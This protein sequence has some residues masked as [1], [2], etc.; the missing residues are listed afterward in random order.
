M[1]RLLPLTLLLLASPT[2]L[3]AQT[4]VSFHGRLVHVDG[5]ST[6]NLKVGFGQFGSAVTRSNG[7]FETALPAGVA[8]IRIEILDH[9]W[10]VL[11]PRDGRVPVPRDPQQVAEIIVGESVETAALRLFAE[12]HEKLAAG[13]ESV[14]ARQDEV[15]DILRQFVEEVTRRLEVDAA[16]LQQAIDFQR[17]RIEH[18]PALSTT[19]K[20]YVLEARNLTGFFKRYGHIAF[21]DREVYM[22]LHDAVEKYN[23]AFDRLNNERL[24]S[25]FRV[26][27]YWESEELRSD[28]RALYDYALGEIHRVRILQLNESL[29]TMHQALWGGLRDRPRIQRAQEDI[30]GIVRDL[31]LRLPELDTR[32]DRVLQFLSRS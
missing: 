10:T 12:R 7:Q 8:D 24:A 14:G 6:A 25:E 21:T 32:A 5:L 27:T 11:Y 17:S 20:S 3:K 29:P 31:E 13:L 16:S 28:L 1:R 2:G 4:P 19:I 30:D 9:Y 15:S 26:A 23:A 22:G 18:Y